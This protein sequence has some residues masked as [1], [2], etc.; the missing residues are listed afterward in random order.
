M[1]QDLIGFWNQR[2]LKGIIPR[3]FVFVNDPPSAVLLSFL[4][5]YGLMREKYALIRVLE[6]QKIKMVIPIFVGFTLV[7]ELM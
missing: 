7:A 4:L 6:I 5:F 3:V 2:K 1:P